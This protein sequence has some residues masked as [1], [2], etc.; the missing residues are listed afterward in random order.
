MTPA[1]FLRRHWQKRPLL[2]RQ[3]FPGFA[4]LVDV[5]ALFSFAVEPGAV[6]RVVVERASRAGSRWSLYDGAL[7]DPHKLPPSRWTV[8]LQGA[9]GFVDG[10]WDLLRAF[11]FIPAARVDDLMISYAAPGGSV[12]PHVDLYDVFLLQGPGRRRWRIETGSSTG[13]RAVD[14]RA[15][16]K[17]LTDFAPD[18][19]WVLEPGDMLYLPPGVAHHGVAV[20]GCFTY[21]IGF[22]APSLESLVQNWLAYLAQTVE[23]D[24]LALYADPSLR[25][26]SDPVVLPDEMVRAVKRLVA[27]IG[28][29]VEEFLGRLLTGPKPHVVFDAPA[30]PVSPSRFA[31]RLRGR[32]ALALARKSRGLVCGGRVFLN[33]EALVVDKETRD[34]LATLFRE[35]AVAL[36]FS[37]PDDAVAWLHGAY[38]AGWL[39]TQ[40]NQARSEAPAERV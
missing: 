29:D 30:R 5:D 6:S 23:I 17:V 22:L 12:G 40:R 13:P 26:P 25:V 27:G 32:G 3:A 16:I 35:R 33:G 37:A 9:E 10:G 36:P 4:G 2:V 1:T 11:S 8:L 18:A 34:V 20:D 31:A 19:E 14:E 7:V 39:R 21:S 28:G 38:A 15:P 24:P